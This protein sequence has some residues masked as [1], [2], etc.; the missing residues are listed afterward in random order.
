[1]KRWKIFYTGSWFKS[2]EEHAEGDLVLYED[3]LVYGNDR[4]T[5]GYK[6]G[7]KDA[8]KGQ[9]CANCSSILTT[10]SDV[11]SQTGIN[12]RH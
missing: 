5:Q 10:A 11:H 12:H 9:F 8:T 1:M 3:A 7:I 4:E 2:L 6:W